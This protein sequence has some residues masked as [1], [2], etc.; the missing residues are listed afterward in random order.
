MR[1]IPE[2]ELM[3]QLASNQRAQK[4]LESKK[5]AQKALSETEL[6]E[7]FIKQKKQDVQQ[8]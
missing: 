2:R 8:F 5:R 1:K 7:I 4:V 6:M 3:E